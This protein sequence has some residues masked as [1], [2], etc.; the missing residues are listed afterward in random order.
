[1]KEQEGG[2]STLESAARVQFIRL[3]AGREMIKSK[4]RSRNEGL[5]DGQ[6]YMLCFSEIYSFWLT[7]KIKVI[8]VRSFQLIGLFKILKSGF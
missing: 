4:T 3:R 6:K 7:P 5:P 1:M 8:F 2:G